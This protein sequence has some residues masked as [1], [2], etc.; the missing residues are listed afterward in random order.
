MPHVV[1]HDQKSSKHGD[2]AWTELVAV[3]R[4]GSPLRLSKHEANHEREDEEIEHKRNGVACVSGGTG[5]CSTKKWN[6]KCRP[7][8]CSNEGGNREAQRDQ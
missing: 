5:N 4:P 8:S 6:D 2:I 3:A 1:C 7:A